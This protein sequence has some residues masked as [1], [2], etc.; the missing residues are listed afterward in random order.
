MIQKYTCV[1]SSEYEVLVLT[2]G[3]I[4]QVE[5]KLEDMNNQLDKPIHDNY[6]V[7]Y[8]SSFGELIHYLD[9]FKQDKRID[10]EFNGKIFFM[11]FNGLSFIQGVISDSLDYY[12]TYMR[13]KTKAHYE[14]L[15]KLEYLNFDIQKYQ[16][17]FNNHNKLNNCY[18]YFDSTIF[19][20]EDMHFDDSFNFL[21][22]I[23]NDVLKKI[24]FMVG[25]IR[26]IVIDD[27]DLQGEKVFPIHCLLRNYPGI[28]RI[29][30]S[31][32]SSLSM[33]DLIF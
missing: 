29:E 33:K 27:F 23:V 18:F 15:H 30:L 1:P 25:C 6:R 3:S 12:Q 8:F 16:N 19:D 2:N 22:T 28:E 11:F 32:E 10:V 21:V 20:A 14:M 4:Q 9:D 7:T 26:G 17:R 13:E 5:N 31:S 24:N